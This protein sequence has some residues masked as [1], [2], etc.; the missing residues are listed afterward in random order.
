MFGYTAEEM[1]GQ[2]VR[3]L[4]PDDRQHEEDDVLAGS[5]AVNGLSTTR[6]SAGGKTARCSRSR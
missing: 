5:R 3:L 2:S 6:R 1:I 4:I